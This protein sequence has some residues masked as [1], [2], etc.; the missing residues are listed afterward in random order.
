M[1]RKRISSGSPYEKPIGFSRAVRTGS[2]ILVSG[3]APIAG[4]GSPAYPGDVYRQTL[5]CLQIIGKAILE[6]GGRLEVCS[7]AD[8]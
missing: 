6:A 8:S 7:S 3:T 2:R 1:S 5:H 4:D